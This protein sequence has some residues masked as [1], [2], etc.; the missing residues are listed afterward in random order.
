MAI[1]SR[2]DSLMYRV[3]E[4]KELQR[5]QECLQ[6]KID[7]IKLE[8]MEKLYKEGRYEKEGRK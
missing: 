4:A 5:Q 8:A 1:I 2:E 3:T 6:A 7:A